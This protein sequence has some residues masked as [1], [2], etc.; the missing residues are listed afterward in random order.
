[1]E[2]DVV[3][4]TLTL[5]LNGNQLLSR[6]NSSLTTGLVGISGKYAAFT[7]FAAR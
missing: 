2:F 5:S 7:S 4:S 3:G 1:L 6:T